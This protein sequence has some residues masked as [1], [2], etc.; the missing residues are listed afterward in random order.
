MV[1]LF[2]KKTGAEKG[3]SSVEVTGG[4]EELILFF[5]LLMGEEETFDQ[6]S[7]LRLPYRDN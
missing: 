6:C 3:T 1:D 2:G 7:L 5:L 4:E